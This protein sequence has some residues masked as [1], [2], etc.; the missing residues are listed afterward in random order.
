MTV[1]VTLA[2][3]ASV[4]E[5]V[6]VRASVSPSWGKNTDREDVTKPRAAYTSTERVWGSDRL[7]ARSRARTRIVYRP[8]GTKPSAPLPSQVSV[9]APPLSAAAIEST[10]LPASSSTVATSDPDSLAVPATAK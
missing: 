5:K 2:G 4:I 1:Q 10:S 3:E 7:P 8:S 6:V 9:A